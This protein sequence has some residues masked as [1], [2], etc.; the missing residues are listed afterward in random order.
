MPVAEDVGP[1]AFSVSA[2]GILV[3]QRGGGR[4]QLTWFDRHGTNL[5]TVAEPFLQVRALSPPAVSP[6]GKRVA[7]TRGDTS[8]NADIWLFE[9][10]RGISTPFTMGPGFNG[11]PL[12][13]PDGSRIAFV[14]RRPG[15]SGLYQKASNLSGGEELLYKADYPAS[16]DL[17]IVPTS[18]SQ[19]G[20]F[21][22]YGSGPTGGLWRLAMDVPGSHKA[23][24]LVP[25][26]SGPRG[27]VFSPDGRFFTYT[28][29]KASGDDVYLR[30]FDPSTGSGS[31]VAGGEWKV[32]RDGGDGGHWGKDGKEIFYGAPDG[33]MMAVEVTTTPVF[34]L[35]TPKPLFRSTALTNANSRFANWTVTPDGQRFLIPV[36]ASANAE[37]SYTVVL[38]WQAALKQ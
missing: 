23:V 25:Q 4:Q 5:G 36:P 29:Q 35:G 32:S 3:Y 18:W 16:P 2:N 26:Q 17:G 33:T 12:W 10:A 13:S 24:L 21:F 22:L 28:S 15:A 27:A 9:F 38:N 20:R 7:Y 6:D 37:A 34:Q 8:G 30:S 11:N 31:A 1:A 19:D 14:G